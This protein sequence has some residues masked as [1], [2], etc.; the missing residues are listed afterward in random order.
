MRRL[1]AF[2]AGL[3][4]A[5]GVLVPG[6][7]AADGTLV[8]TGRVLLS[9]SGDLTVAAG[10]QADLVVVISGTA[11][12][13]GI[14]NTIVVVDGSAILN[15]A[16]TETLVAVRSPVTLG[17]GTVV[18]GDVAT[19]DSLVTRVGN[20]S[21]GGSIRDVAGDLAGIGFALGPAL[22]LF[23]LGFAI[24]TVA[25]GLLLAALA[26]RQVRA[27]EAMISHEPVQTL[28]AG[29]AGTIVPVAAVIALFMT[30]IGAPLA[31]GILF[32]LLPAAAFIGYLVAA[33]WIGDLILDRT[34]PG[35]VRERPYLAAVIGLV[36]LAIVTALPFVTAIASLF[37]FGAVV[38][39]GWR[40][41]RSGSA[42]APAPSVRAAPIAAPG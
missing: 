13:A 30:I 35:V 9:T 4:L 6:V 17:A 2:G 15:G 38:L 33:I 8:H 25:A 16:T 36:V 34:S 23:F 41:F 29:L 10:E 39:L 11:R 19:F 32:F 27:A 21:V 7:L 28:V 26:A 18:L 1:V 3:F 40:T 24:A 20:A 14:V 31:F 22:L 5:F 37:G 42:A 12:I